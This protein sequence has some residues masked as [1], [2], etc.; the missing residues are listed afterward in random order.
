MTPPDLAA[1][2]PIANALVPLLERAGVA[3]GDEAELAVA[4]GLTWLML[5]GASGGLLGVLCPQ[6]GT[7]EA[8]VGC[9]HV[10]LVRQPRL[11]RYVAAIAVADRMRVIEN[12][13][14]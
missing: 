13:L 3:V 11:D 10:P 4:I 1:N 9:C 12:L 2:T 7:G 8:V 6:R 14:Q 5:G